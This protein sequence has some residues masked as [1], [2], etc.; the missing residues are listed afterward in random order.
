MITGGSATSPG[1][2]SA[3]MVVDLDRR[4]ERIRWEWQE[5]CEQARSALSP[6]LPELN[7][8][9]HT[10]AAAV[11]FGQQHAAAHARSAKS[12]HAVGWVGLLASV[13]LAEPQLSADEAVAAAADRLLDGILDEIVAGAVVGDIDEEV[14]AAFE[15]LPWSDP[16]F[17]A[18]LIARFEA[19]ELLGMVWSLEQGA[20]RQ[21]DF[22]PAG[23]LLVSSFAEAFATATHH[24]AFDVTLVDQ[25]VDHATHDPSDAY[26]LSLLLRG[27]HSFD[28]GVALHL[29]K[30][31][32]DT[33]REGDT[34][35][36]TQQMLYDSGIDRDHAGSGGNPALGG[37]DTYDLF[38]A[39]AA[40]LSH[41]PVAA[42]TFLLSDDPAGGD[43]L[44]HL[45]AHEWVDIPAWG[46]LIVAAS[47][48]VRGVGDPGDPE[49]DSAV[50][51]ARFLH[52]VPLGDDFPQGLASALSKV[53]A[54]YILDLAAAAPQ[55][56]PDATP[57]E[58]FDGAREQVTVAY[59]AIG[60]DVV[61]DRLG[62]LYA[63][64]V[65]DESQFD[66]L[67]ESQQTLLD[68]QL[69]AVHDTAGSN[70]VE[71]L[72]GLGEVLHAHAFLG[73]HL[74]DGG[75]L[76]ERQTRVDRDAR[77]ARLLNLGVDATAGAAG[78]LP[79]AGWLLAPSASVVLS[80]LAERAAPDGAG[81]VRDARW[82]EI[83]VMQLVLRGQVRPRLWE[84]GWFEP[85][86][87]LA[88]LHPDRLDDIE[89]NFVT[90]EGQLIDYDRLGEGQHQQ[91]L[92]WDAATH[93]LIWRALDQA[94]PLENVHEGWG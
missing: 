73:M 79:V 49:Y 15:V 19:D 85:G 40:M 23:Q 57:G 37:P 92:D 65:A 38:G 42:Q 89:A 35:R 21:E 59:R 50:I 18:A 84:D 25:L 24:P 60:V 5:A 81:A 64:A 74:V 51:A 63:A 56:D 27:G 94:L 55:A 43:R 52:E 12:G 66:R 8:T 14:I 4:A 68:D 1:A 78:R 45:I 87:P 47:T 54:S 28:R 71:A 6:L 44:D 36:W 22:A 77:H 83:A 34:A 88:D 3:S 2:G 67:L 61:R 26:A 31:I 69:C 17:A 7:V 86:G 93:E 90:S 10:R 41:D 13:R 29:A 58:V 46:S 32:Y 72:D 82:K 30:R 70:V 11:S 33:D 53:M 91:L 20:R 39:V 80:E 48:E 16:A 75:H 62:D 9:E 76:Y